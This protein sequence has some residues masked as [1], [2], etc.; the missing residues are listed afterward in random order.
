MT[1]KRFLSSMRVLLALLPN[2]G[3]LCCAQQEMSVFDE[4]L[5]AQPFVND[6][7]VDCEYCDQE[8]AAFDSWETVFDSSSAAP[9]HGPALRPF[10]WVRHFGFRHSSTHGRHVGRGIPLESTSWKNR[11]YHVDWFLGSFLGDELI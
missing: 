10:D 11:P 2:S 1:A 7:P 6:V 5:F 8:E 3:T 9:W 4:N